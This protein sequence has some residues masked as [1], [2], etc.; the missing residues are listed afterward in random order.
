MRNI[1][2]FMMIF[3]F[4]IVSLHADEIDDQIINF[5]KRRLSNNARV[6]IKE[7]KINKKTKIKSKKTK[8]Y[9]YILDVNIKV[10]EKDMNVKDVIFSNG[11]VVTSELIDLKTGIS[12]KD[13]L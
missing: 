8:W 1:R 2:N 12:L 7:V 6:E 5:E 4:F 9:A 10:K 13:G 11:F 3:I